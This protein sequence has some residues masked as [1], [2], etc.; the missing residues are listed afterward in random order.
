MK[1]KLKIEE[2]L[3]KLLAQEDTDKDKKITIEDEGPKKFFLRTTDGKDIIVKG[4]YYLSNFLQELVLA[5]ESGKEIAEIDFAYIF[6]KPVD[7]ISRMI[8]DYYWDGLT[9]R[10]DAEGIIKALVDTKAETKKYFLYVPFDDDK[11]FEYYNEVV[12]KIKE[13]TITVVKLPGKITPEYVRSINNKPGV[14]S[15]DLV[16]NEKGKTEGMPFVVPGGRF[17]EMYGWDSYFEALGLLIDGR[18]DLAKAMADNLVYEI[19]HYG[20][21]LNANR[22]YYLT[23]SQPPFLTS[24]AS[25]V[26]NHLKD[27]NKKEWLTKLLNASIKE[28]NTVWMS[29]HKLTETK[30]SRYFGTGIGLAPETELTHF[31]SVLKPYAEKE[32]LTVRDYHQ[33]YLNREIVHPQIEEFIKHDRSIRE[34]GHDTSY[35]LDNISADLNT[36]DLNSLLYKY[37]VDIAEIIKNEFDNYF[38]S[39][40]GTVENS[41][42]WFEKAELRKSI[43]NNLMWNGEKGFF[44]DYNFV[45]KEQTGFESA[46]AFY[47]LWAKLATQEQADLLVEKALPLLEFKGGIAGTS[48][49]SVG[50]INDERPQK[51][52]DYPNGWAPHQII[53]WKG[54]KNYGYD[55]TAE[56]LAYKWFYMILKNA[57][58]YNGTIPEKYDVVTCTHKVFA[59]YGNVGTEFD[60]ISRE[61]FGWMNASFEVGLTIL[62]NE[63]REKLNN[64]VPAEK[65]F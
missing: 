39:Y 35:R 61:G 37:E 20:Q 31:D 3:N 15:L 56:R 64:L 63:L 47:P 11:A 54:L 58:E 19:E 62:N 44:F 18:V 14:L 10:I 46:T 50:I 26:Y 5:K 13:I 30:L 60:Y 27:E 32:G 23:R 59:E 22:T 6:E 65:L 36:V 4:T 51:Q 49:E 45:K 29:E 2:T 41:E 12:K 21:I 55:K 16:K 28:Y 24:F 38:V 52:W 53:I 42:R 7:R 9:R 25:A 1:L 48:K 40:N 17:N 8:K 34:S 57:V 43:M 33:K